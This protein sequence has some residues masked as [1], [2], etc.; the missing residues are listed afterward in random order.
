MFGL[1]FEIPKLA[2]FRPSNVE[3]EIVCNFKTEQEECMFT[4]ESEIFNVQEE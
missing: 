3:F 2:I 4:V 1:S